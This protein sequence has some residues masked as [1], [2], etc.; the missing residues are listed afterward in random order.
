MSLPFCHR[1]KHTYLCIKCQSVAVHLVFSAGTK[2]RMPSARICWLFTIICGVSETNRFHAAYNGM[3]S[4]GVTSMRRF[5]LNYKGGTTLPCFQA[6]SSG[7]SLM[8]AES[9]RKLFYN[10]V[11]SSSA[12]QILVVSGWSGILIHFTFSLFTLLSLVHKNCHQY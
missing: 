9:L 4:S 2:H 1:P 10:R 11:P 7:W 12:C 6:R 5:Y 3:S 8:V